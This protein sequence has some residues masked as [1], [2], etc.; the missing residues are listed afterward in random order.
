MRARPLATLLVVEDDE[1]GRYMLRTLLSGHGYAIDS[2]DDG[3]QALDRLREKTYDLVITDL[4]MPNLD[5]FGLC[6]AMKADPALRA[7]PVLVYTATYTAPEDERLA[8][9]AG[10]DG[11]LVKPAAPAAIVAEVATLLGARGGAAPELPGDLDY[12]RLHQARLSEKLLSKVAELEAADGE[13]REREVLLHALAQAA[14]VGILYLSPDERVVYANER[15]WSLAGDPVA[16]EWHAAFHPEDRARARELWSEARRKDQETR[17]EVRIG[18][19]HASWAL[20]QVKPLHVGPAAAHGY[21]VIVTD[22]TAEKA[23]AHRQKL[24]SLGTLVGGF[25]HEFA[26]LLV[27]ILGYTQYALEAKDL[28]ASARND[29]AQV[30]KAAEA[31]RELTR[32]VLTF[33]RQEP[34]EVSAV[35]LAAVLRGAVRLL[36]PVV[37]PAVQLDT[38]MAPDLPRARG[39]E[40]H[41]QQVVLNLARNAIDAIGEAGGRV[42]LALALEGADIA[43]TV[44]DSGAGIAADV[45]PRIFDPFFTTKPIGQG[46]GLGLSVVHGIVTQHGGTI[47]VDSVPGQG[48]TVRV[49]LP[50]APDLPDPA[51]AT[52]A[53]AGA[54]RRVLF[55]DDDAAHCDLARRALEDHGYRVTTFTSPKDAL[56]ALRDDPGNFDLLITDD[57]MPVLRGTELAARA[58]KQRPG[59]PVLLMTSSAARKAAPPAVRETLRKPFSLDELKKAAAR[60]L[61]KR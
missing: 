36:R 28:P 29:L 52:A 42:E 56:V 23:Q 3:L 38:R 60:A 25:A 58:V 15:W 43:M 41:M 16:G 14:P 10:A 6:R 47:T 20:V 18:A 46:T 11:Y 17:G 8:R 45:L 33:A 50:L 59:L 1:Q 19:A 51:A 22:V 34:G 9:A 49:K 26:N 27:P 61:A 12:A 31:S 13:R 37:P 44:T 32:H 54:A 53:E 30:L 57:A 40:V 24:E 35:D 55:V 2:A 21:L 5:G 4:L 39:V 48:T 7:I